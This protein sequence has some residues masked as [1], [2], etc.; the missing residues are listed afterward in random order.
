MARTA[1]INRKTNET[2]INLALNLDGVGEHQIT[3]GIGFFDHMLSHLAYQSLIDLTVTAQGDLEVDGHH[4]VED[5][6]I[7]LGEALREALGN[8]KGINRYGAAVVPMDDALVLAAVDFSGRTYLNFDLPLG[9]GQVGTFALELAEEF[10]S[11]LCRAG[12]TIHLRSLAGKNRHHL[13]EA[14]FKAL[15]Q[16]FRQAITLDPR[17]GEIPSTK[18]ILL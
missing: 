8:K 18:G 9:E 4:T 6:G 11:A 13:L 10:F 12:I 1:T 17:R 16:A 7:V 5:I 15:G 2:V 14:A 3:T